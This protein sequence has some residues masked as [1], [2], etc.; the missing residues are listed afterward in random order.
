MNQS[1]VTDIKYHDKVDEYMGENS[2]WNIFLNEI[3]AVDGTSS[4]ACIRTESDNDVLQVIV[5]NVIPDLKKEIRKVKDDNLKVSIE[6]EKLRRV[7]IE[8]R[9]EILKLTSKKWYQF[10]K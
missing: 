1:I 7:V 4:T 2:Y 5:H 10:W 6:L 3:D 9:S 8:Q